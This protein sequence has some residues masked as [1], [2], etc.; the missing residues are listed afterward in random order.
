MEIGKLN[1]GLVYTNEECIGCNHCISVCPVFEANYSLTKDGKDLIYVN[2]DACIHCGAC[3][4]ACHH[5]ARDF[6]DD[7][8]QFLEDLKKGESISLL[9]AP[10]FIANYPGQYGKVLGYLKSLGAKHVIS[11][12]FGADITTWGYLNYIAEKNFTGGISQP[13]PAIV[14]YIEKYV[15]DLISR[16]VPVHSPMMCAAIYAKKYMNITDKLAFIGPCIAKKSEIMRPDNRPYVSYNVTFHHLMNALKG[17]NLSS[18]SAVD[19]LEYGLG[20][21]YPQPGGLKE[22][23]EHFLGKDVMV[24]QIEGESHAYHF[25]K[26]YAKRVKSGRQLPFMVDALN[27]ANGCLHGTG[28]EPETLE[29][30]DVLFEINN[31][32]NKA[33]SGK[34]DKKKD[35]NNPWGKG[36][37]YEKRLANFNAQFAELKLEDF[38]CRYENK[39]MAASVNEHQVEAGFEDMKKDT[40][41]KREIDCGACGYESCRQMAE[42]V[43]LGLN[44]KENCMHYEKNALQ[45]E[46]ER[47][48]E[49]TEQLR[50]SQKRKQILYQEIMN[51]FQQIKTAMG[52]LAEGNQCSAEDATRIAQAVGG[53]SS[54]TEMLRGSMQQVV[55]AV[56]GYDVMN[57]SIIK[58]SNQTGM[59]ALNAG[60]EA[61]RSG[62][63]GKGFAVIANR[64]RD[65]SEQTK[66]AVA[67][68]KEQSTILIPAIQKLDDETVQFVQNIENINDGTSALAASSQEIA[69]QTEMIDEVVNRMA[70]KM[71]EVVD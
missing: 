55:D 34:Q 4:D 40:R 54:F 2:G 60:I 3:I 13:C 46:Q 7:T 19:E 16:I 48:R 23:V 42:A 71:K 59:L 57:E 63:A 56:Q 22:N 37:T 39:H 17:V 6:R 68:G 15:P 62:E 10:A 28:V 70:E 29:N 49:I 26:G 35:K 67:T 58:I 53:M 41:E 43:A 36:L 18:Y 51:D 50:E 64:V 61:A 11:V 20:S 30:D 27:C 66:A 38:I 69:A 45:E 24:R 65:L 9:V 25:L 47:M 32:R 1:S 33:K 44:R 14:D 21:V 12:S 31:Q 5:H 52:E 8:E